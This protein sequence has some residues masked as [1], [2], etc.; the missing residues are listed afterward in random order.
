M[1]RGA[2]VLIL[3]AVVLSGVALD[4]AVKALAFGALTSPVGIGGVIQ[5]RA[6][7]NKG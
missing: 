4:Q 3:V 7:A 2:R 6:I 5:L 1:T